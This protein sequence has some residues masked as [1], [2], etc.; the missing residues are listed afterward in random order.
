M[1][2]ARKPASDVVASLLEVQRTALLAG[3]LKRLDKMAK[4]L[5]QAFARLERDGGNQPALEQIRA[6]AA[7]NARLLTAA[8]AGVAAA[9]GHLSA[10]RAPGLTTYDAQGR[11]QASQ[12]S[13]SRDLARR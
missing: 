2:G 11:S 12:A 8:Q 1:I 5:P 9:R 10:S 3:D 7:R 13:Q 4:E 6:A